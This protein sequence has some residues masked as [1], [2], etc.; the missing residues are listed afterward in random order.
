MEMEA[1]RETE[2]HGGKQLLSLLSSQSGLSCP[3]RTTL[4]VPQ[5]LGNLIFGSDSTLYW[6]LECW[7]MR[8][9]GVPIIPAFRIVPS[10]QFLSTSYTSLLSYTSQ[11]RLVH[12]V[13]T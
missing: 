12:I 13:A 2:R 10:S 8:S 6:A 3:V 9:D 4:V 5:V 1:G 11:T 7:G